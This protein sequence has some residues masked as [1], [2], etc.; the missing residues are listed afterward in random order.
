MIER[1]EI[2]LAVMDHRPPCVQ[3]CWSDD[4]GCAVYR[5]ARHA[6]ELHSLVDKLSEGSVQQ[7]ERKWCAE[8]D[9]DP[10][11]VEW[12]LQCGLTRMAATSDQKK[13]ENI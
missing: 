2:D 9:H 7:P 1:V 10:Y 8:H 11:T 12:C 4:R 5:L 13:G 6:Q 3:G